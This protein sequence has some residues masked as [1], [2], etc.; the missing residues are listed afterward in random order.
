MDLAEVMRQKGEEDMLTVL[1]ILRS[2]TFLFL[3]FSNMISLIVASRNNNVI[4]DISS[5]A[6]FFKNIDRSWG[7]AEMRK[8]IADIDPTIE[9]RDILFFRKTSTFTNWYYTKINTY[10]ALKDDEMKPKVRAKQEKLLIKSAEMAEKT[11]SNVDQVTTRAVVVFSSLY[12]RAQVYKK[13]S[14][15]MFG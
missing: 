12:D 8:A 6:L 14:V 11:A 13:Y 4:I 3:I 1:L 2:I 9:I 7:E 5:Y 15:S 10:F